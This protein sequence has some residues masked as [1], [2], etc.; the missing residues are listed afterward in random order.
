MNTKVIQWIQSVNLLALEARN[1]N[2][3]PMLASIFPR[4]MMTEGTKESCTCE[5]CIY[6]CHNKPGWFLPHEIEKVAEFLSMDLKDL[7]DQFL[8][9]D[10]YL[11]TSDIP[12]DTPYSHEAAKEEFKK[13]SLFVIA[14][15]QDRMEPGSMYPAKPVGRCVF[16]D[17]NDRCKIHV[18][19]PYQCREAFHNIDHDGNEAS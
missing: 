17:E 11:N 15:A 7:F 8:G 1:A 9:V 5:E 6:A 13:V 18:V 4:G 16:L 3:A 10:Y 12:E 14:P 19:K 2:V